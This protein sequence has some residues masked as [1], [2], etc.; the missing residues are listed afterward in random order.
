M[1]I[2]EDTFLSQGVHDLRVNRLI[3][4]DEG[5]WHLLP[6]IEHPLYQLDHILEEPRSH[7]QESQREG[8]EPVLVR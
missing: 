2:I 3:R 8:R 5:L 4:R 6:P 1:K 7:L